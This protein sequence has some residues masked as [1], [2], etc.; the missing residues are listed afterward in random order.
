[1]TRIFGALLNLFTPQRVDVPAALDDVAGIA[2]SWAG[3]DGRVGAAQGDFRARSDGDV[4]A[5]RFELGETGAAAW[6]MVFQ[7]PSSDERGVVWRTAAR[8]AALPRAYM[9]VSLPGA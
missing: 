2:L 4:R 7:H 9:N 8:R 1:M 5:Q 6:R 3:V